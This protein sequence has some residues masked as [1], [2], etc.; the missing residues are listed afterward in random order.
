MFPNAIRGGAMAAA[1]FAQWIANWLVTI[2][3]PP[4]VSAAGPGTT[5]AVYLVFT[6]VSFVFVKRFVTETRG[7]VLEDM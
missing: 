2:S 3:F 5:Y 1:V 7:R 4:L 6:L